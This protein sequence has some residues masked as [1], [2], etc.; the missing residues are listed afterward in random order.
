MRHNT[1]LTAFVTS[2]VSEVKKR[3]ERAPIVTHLNLPG[4][5][6]NHNS[7]VTPVPQRSG[8]TQGASS[9]ALGGPSMDDADAEK[10]KRRHI[11]LQHQL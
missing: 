6:D 7:S 5:R 2:P 8:M 3:R 4:S 10:E 9:N 11:Q 1:A